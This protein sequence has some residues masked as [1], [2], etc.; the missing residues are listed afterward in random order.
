MAAAGVEIVAPMNPVV[1]LVEIFG[2]FRE[3]LASFAALKKTLRE[4][5]PGLIVLIDNPEFNIRLARIA[6]RAGVPV[7]YYVSPQV[8]AWRKGRA[9]KIARVIDGMAV[10]LPFEQSIYESEGVRTVYTGH[11]IVE[12]ILSWSSARKEETPDAKSETRSRIL[13]VLPGSRRGEVDRHGD[14]LAD[15]ILLIKRRFPEIIPLVPIAPGLPVESRERL[16]G[17]G[18]AGAILTEE[19]SWEVFRKAHVALVASGTA[20][21]EAAVFGVPTVVFYRLKTLSYLVGKM[22]VDVPHVSLANLLLDERVIPEY[23]QNEATPASLAVAVGQLVDEEEPRS[24]MIEA[25]SRVRGILGN[26]RASALAADLA[27]E[28]AGC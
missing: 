14:L 22:L 20:S 10:I 3:I 5:R 23:I 15:T 13:A 28:I 4:R 8:W 12:E 16:E 27:E 24:H 7:M 1:G 2:Q 21:L 11:P 17:L 26:T 6:R 18:K 9:R 19:S 25:F